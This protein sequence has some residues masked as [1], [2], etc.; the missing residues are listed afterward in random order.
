MK[1]LQYTGTVPERELQL[2]ACSVYQW[3]LDDLVRQ[4]AAEDWG[5]GIYCLTSPDYYNR[6]TGISFEATDYLI[7]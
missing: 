2:Y 6:K 1:K 4:H 7:E 3:E 5:S